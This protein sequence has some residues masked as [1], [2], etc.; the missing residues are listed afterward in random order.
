[1]WLFLRLPHF[2]VIGAYV[3]DN[4]WWLMMK[5]LWDK[6]IN[7]LNENSHSIDGTEDWG[8]Q[9]KGTTYLGYWLSLHPHTW[10]SM[11]MQEP[12]LFTKVVDS[13]RQ[14][15]K[16]GFLRC[17]AIYPLSQLVEHQKG[18]IHPQWKWTLANSGCCWSPV[19]W[20]AQ[21]VLGLGCGNI[22]WCCMKSILLP[23]NLVQATDIFSY[24]WVGKEFNSHVHPWSKSQ[25]T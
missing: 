14:D 23:H 2:N 4:N 21:N 3:H 9:Q 18:W 1:M 6:H 8:R 19:G 22:L 10:S 20:T 16:L 5:Q 7:I 15:Q 11:G 25:L 17:L 12:F 13:K 24:L